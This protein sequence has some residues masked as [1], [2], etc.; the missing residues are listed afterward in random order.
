MDQA[1]MFRGGSEEGGESLEELRWY[2]PLCSPLALRLQHVL[3]GLEGWLN[4]PPKSSE[5][6][7][8][9]LAPALPPY[10]TVLQNR[11]QPFKS[12]GCTA[13]SCP[14]LVK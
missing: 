10:P 7:F 2:P 13:R 1:Q 11:K 12:P 14:Y 4:Q 5:R 6:L 8:S 9:P 3:Q